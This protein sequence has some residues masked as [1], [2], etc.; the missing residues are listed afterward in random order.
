[1]RDW[2]NWLLPLLTCLAVVCLAVLP[3]RLSALR[4]RG[5]TGAVHTEALGENSNFPAK[6][7]EL[8]GRLW[9]LAQLHSFPDTLT[10]VEQTIED[11]EM[12]A[13]RPEILEELEALEE[14]G[15][16]P[17]G[18]REEVENLSGSRVY[19]RDQADL[20][21]AAFWQVNAFSDQTGES[22]SLYLDR[23]TGRTAALSFWSYR[24]R[25]TARLSPAEAGMAL[26]DRLEVGYEAAQRE[27]GVETVLRLEESR[28]L[29][30]ILDLRT[31]LRIIPD[32]DWEALDEEDGALFDIAHGMDAEA[33]T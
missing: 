17:E 7:P 25:K 18:V 12:E 14:A 21:S 28:V 23:E 19:L 4:D 3:P 24:L 22:L 13:L 20:S 10:I 16:L 30:D 5:L 33:Y 2:K 26:L 27:S 29:Y 9:L 6:P 31:H 32:V 8:S 1:M 11:E 15:I